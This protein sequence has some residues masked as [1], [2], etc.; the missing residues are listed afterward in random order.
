MLNLKAKAMIENIIGNALPRLAL[1][2]STHLTTT[3]VWIPKRHWNGSKK[4]EGMLVLRRQNV[5]F[6]I[7]F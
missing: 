6:F 4:Q 5:F 3:E 7:G 2:A 1:L